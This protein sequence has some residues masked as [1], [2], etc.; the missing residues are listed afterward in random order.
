MGVWKILSK[1]DFRLTTH[2]ARRH[3][4]GTSI[5][6]PTVYCPRPAVTWDRLLLSMYCHCRLCGMPLVDAHASMGDMKRRST[7]W[8]ARSA[9]YGAEVRRVAHAVGDRKVAVRSGARG[10]TLAAVGG[11]PNYGPIMVLSFV[12]PER[13]LSSSDENQHGLKAAEEAAL[14]R[15]L[16]IVARSGTQTKWCVFSAAC[17]ASVFVEGMMARVAHL[18]HMET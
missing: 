12:V 9:R 17:G 8:A 14:T 15:R 5:D 4:Y 16:Y 6:T 10:I 13:H 2:A 11:A 7:S 1:S 3:D 18:K